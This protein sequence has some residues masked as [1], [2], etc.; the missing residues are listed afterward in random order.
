M[1]A[2]SF[3][4]SRKKVYQSPCNDQTKKAEQH[5]KEKYSRVIANFELMNKPSKVRAVL[6]IIMT[7][8]RSG[9]NAGLED[10]CHS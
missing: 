7:E 5:V 1:V 10:L 3:S 2:L 8:E 9:Y 6:C 4:L